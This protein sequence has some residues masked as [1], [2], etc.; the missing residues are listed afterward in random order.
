MASKDLVPAGLPYGERAG[1][2]QSMQQAGLPLSSGAAANQAPTPIIPTD[3]PP[4][5][6][7]TPNNLPTPA[8]GDPLL[9][10]APP[11]APVPMLDGPAQLRVI[12]ERSPNPFMQLMAQ[13]LLEE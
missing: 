1:V 2:Q 12:L 5:N 7:P 4:G 9:E 3:A 11:R 10:I 8:S 6:Q 13:R